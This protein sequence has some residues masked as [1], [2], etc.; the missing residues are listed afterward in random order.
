MVSLIAIVPDSECSTPTLIGSPAARARDG[1]TAAVIPAAAGSDAAA[2]NN[3]RRVSFI[4]LL[5][6]NRVRPGRCAGR[7]WRGISG[8]ISLQ[9]RAGL[10]GCRR[11]K[12]T[13][14]QPGPRPHGRFGPYGTGMPA[15]TAACI[16]FVRRLQR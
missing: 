9:E 10:P 8:A 4:G 3:K 12:M 13:W 14:N 1:A 11:V 7:E 5:L 16:F 6:G 2:L 15:A